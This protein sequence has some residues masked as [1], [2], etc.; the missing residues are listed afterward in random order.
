MAGIATSRDDGIRAPTL[1]V[2]PRQP[3]AAI[4]AANITTPARIPPSETV[5]GD[6]VNPNARG[7]L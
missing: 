4:V 6:G 3:V 7:A 1:I 5:P 2:G